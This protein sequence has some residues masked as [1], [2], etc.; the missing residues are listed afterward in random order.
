MANATNPGG[1][2]TRT[3]KSGS[4]IYFENDRSDNIYILKSGRVILTSIKLDTG[5]EVKEDVRQGEFFGVKSAL[6]KY[7]REETAQTIGETSVLVLRPADFERLIL[8]NVN[9][10]RKMLRVFSNQLRRI[11]KMVQAALGQNENVNPAFE[12]FKIGEYYYKSGVYQQALYA[13]KKYMEHYPDTEY[14]STAMQRIR[15]I[16]TGEASP[17]A[18]EPAAGSAVK[19]RKADEE[20]DDFSFDSGEETE[21]DFSPADDSPGN[22]TVSTELDSFLGDSPLAEL[23]DFTFDEPAGDGIKTVRERIGEAE[24]LYAR[25]RF[26]EALGIYDEL[27]LSGELAE[28]EDQSRVYLEI[29]RCHLRLGHQKEA[30]EKLGIVMKRFP[31]SK[32]ARQAYYEVGGLFEAAKQKDKALAYYKKVMAMPPRD[33]LTEQ[34]AAKVKQLQG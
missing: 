2:N 13:Y 15:A 14:A 32:N 18:R 10:V 16:E 6:G 31:D 23:D 17:G 33:S 22:G 21:A 28:D 20:A 3:Y 9:I 27:A 11:H 34:A 12:L 8:K 1:L 24:E 26:A 19:P 30:V 5:E 29:G 25:K 4:I 7:P